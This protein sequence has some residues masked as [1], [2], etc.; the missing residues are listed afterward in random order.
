VNGPAVTSHDA[1]SF[2]GVQ[3]SRNADRS[4]RLPV[5]KTSLAQFTVTAGNFNS[6]K[7]G[8]FVTTAAARR[9]TGYIIDVGDIVF[10]DQSQQ[11]FSDQSMAGRRPMGAM[12]IGISFG[13]IESDKR[14][15]LGL[16]MLN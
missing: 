11:A 2:L 1:L 3:A 7:L 8:H 16:Q 5:A 10:G 12:E 14:N 9:L 15:S 4:H 13:S 6:Q